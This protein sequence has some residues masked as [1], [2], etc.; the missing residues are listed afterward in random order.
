MKRVVFSTLVL[1]LSGIVLAKATPRHLIGLGTPPMSMS[2]PAIEYMFQPN[3]HF[4]RFG[5]AWL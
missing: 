4:S 3:Q 2:H 1:A 5:N